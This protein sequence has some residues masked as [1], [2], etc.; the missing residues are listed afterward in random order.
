MGSNL[1][2]CPDIDSVS[3]AALPALTR[4][5]RRAVW[6]QYRDRAAAALDPARKWTGRHSLGGL[7]AGPAR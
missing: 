6:T 7:R 2:R 4:V 5:S 1:L 3:E